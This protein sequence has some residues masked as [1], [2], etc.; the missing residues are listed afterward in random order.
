MISGSRAAAPSATPASCSAEAC[1]RGFVNRSRSTR[2]GEQFDYREVEGTPV[3]HF[4]VREASARDE[5]RTDW[6]DLG[7]GG[8]RRRNP[9]GPG[10]R[11]G[12]AHQGDGQG[13][14]AQRGA[15]GRC[16]RPEFAR[17][18]ACRGRGCKPATSR[19]HRCASRIRTFTSGTARRGGHRRRAGGPVGSRRPVAA[20]LESLPDVGTCR[21]EGR[22][23]LLQRDGFRWLAY[24][25]QTGL[26][27]ILA[28]RVEP[29]TSVKRNA[30][31]PVGRTI[32]ASLPSV[33][34]V[35]AHP[36]TRTA[37]ISMVPRSASTAFGPSPRWVRRWVSSRRSGGAPRLL[38]ASGAVT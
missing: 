31:I 21:A 2:S 5:S 16:S 9:P 30:T 25:W 4:A 13:D 11:A 8:E 12:G 38:E 10:G 35:S 22:V 28:D 32:V 37:S 17:L 6:L 24:L 14:S 1:C 19:P 26:G 27:G 23:A 33:T 3:I 34:T 20:S 7:V 36:M 15:H 29:S 18:A